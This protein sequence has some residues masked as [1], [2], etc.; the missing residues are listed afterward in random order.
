MM[1]LYFLLSFSDFKYKSFLIF[2]HLAGINLFCTLTFLILSIMLMFS[3]YKYPMGMDG[4]V[5]IYI[6]GVDERIPYCSLLL[7]C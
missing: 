6:T 7:H 4:G 3:D 1:T 2:I 5:L